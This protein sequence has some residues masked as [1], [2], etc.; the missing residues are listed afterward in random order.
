M[1][2]TDYPAYWAYHITQH[3]RPG[4]RALH[5]LGSACLVAFV[6]EAIVMGIWLPVPAALAAAFGPGLVGHVLFEKSKPEKHH[7]PVWAVISDLRMLGLFLTGR[8]ARAFD[9]PGA[10]RRAVPGTT[11]SEG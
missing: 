9:L 6:T 2:L 5:Y 3:R 11:A 8:L 7:Y 4:N 10:R 1:R